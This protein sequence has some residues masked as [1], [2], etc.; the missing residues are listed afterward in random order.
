[1]CSVTTQ[2]PP[3]KKMIISWL[4]KQK[5]KHLTFDVNLSRGVVCSETVGGHAG[6]ASCVVLEGFTDHQCVQD[7]ISADLYVGRVA[8]LS[9]FTE[10]PGRGG[11]SQLC[12]FN[13]SDFD[14]AKVLKMTVV[15]AQYAGHSFRTS[16]SL[17]V[18]TV[19]LHSQ[20]AWFQKISCQMRLLLNCYS[21]SNFWCPLFVKTQYSQSVFVFIHIYCHH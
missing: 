17:Y 9:T 5:N 13:M 6:V 10:P 20:H 3:N 15:Q 11:E 18:T 16:C 7:T 14:W 2:K 4:K 8:Q 19:L 21:D 1:M 12:Y